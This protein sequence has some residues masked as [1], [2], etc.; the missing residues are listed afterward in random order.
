M[1]PTNSVGFS[2]KTEDIF[3]ALLLDATRPVEEKANSKKLQI[4]IKIANKIRRKKRHSHI[5]I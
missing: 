2:G 1:S 5:K 4:K 3:N